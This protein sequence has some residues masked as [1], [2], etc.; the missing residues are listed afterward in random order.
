MIGRL[1]VLILLFEVGLDS[2]V[3][4]VM[5]VGVASTRVALFGTV[6]T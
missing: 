1:G 5:K 6:C 3:R 4:D 2:T